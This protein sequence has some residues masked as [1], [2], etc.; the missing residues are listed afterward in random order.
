MTIRTHLSPRLITKL[1]DTTGQETPGQGLGWKP[2]GLWYSVD[3]DWERWCAAGMPAWLHDK[4]RYAV[5]LGDSDIL[6]ITTPEMFQA[7][8][9][10]YTTPGRSG[11][12]TIDWPR[13][14]R[15]YD[16][17]EIA[18]YFWQFRLGFDTWWYYSWDCASG[19]VWNVAHVKLTLIERMPPE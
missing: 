16:G 6:M 10:I 4:Y 15:A 1:Y 9:A 8:H 5:D 2:N 18:P 19:C 17:I 11:E 3:D 14:A 13:L 12:S 7:F